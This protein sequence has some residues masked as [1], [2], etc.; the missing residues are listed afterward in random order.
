MGLPVV[1][2]GNRQFKRLSAENVITVDHDVKAI[3][4]AI[5]KQVKNGRYK[6]SKLYFAESTSKK[7]AEVIATVPLYTQKTFVE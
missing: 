6:S 4:K 3:K 2:I 7:I 1:N 5:E